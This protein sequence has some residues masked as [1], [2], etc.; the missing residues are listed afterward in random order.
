M[1]P[2]VP[3]ES[4]GVTTPVG[5]QGQQRKYFMGERDYPLTYTRSSI[6]MTKYPPPY[7]RHRCGNKERLVVNWRKEEDLQGNR[8]P[9]PM[10]SGA[11]EPKSAG[12][13]GRPGGSGQCWARCLR[14]SPGAGAGSTGPGH[15]GI[16]CHWGHSVTQSSRSSDTRAVR[17]TRRAAARRAQPPPCAV[18]Q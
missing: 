2:G 5:S 8:G 7:E 18:I 15:T 14:P 12:A 9:D 4:G 17:G 16:G 10:G 11:H 3:Q 13:P 1:S 6:R